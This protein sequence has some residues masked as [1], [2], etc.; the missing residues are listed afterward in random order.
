MRSHSTTRPGHSGYAGSWHRGFYN[1]R[2]VPIRP[3]FWR[4]GTALTFPEPRVD[5]RKFVQ[6]GRPPFNEYDPGIIVN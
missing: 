1:Q 3:L 2:L 4:M 6:M 5:L